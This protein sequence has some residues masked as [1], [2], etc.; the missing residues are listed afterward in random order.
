MPGSFDNQYPKSHTNPERVDFALRLSIGGTGAPGA[1]AGTAGFAFTR[2]GVGTY[3]FTC[4][5]CV[6][7]NIVANTVDS[8]AAAVSASFTALNPSAG[9]GTMVTRAPGG[10]AADVTSGGTVNII[11][12]VKYKAVD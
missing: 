9:T 10:A 8:A 3:T 5:P 7:M 11:G 2:T 12:T 1:I 4:P 6:D